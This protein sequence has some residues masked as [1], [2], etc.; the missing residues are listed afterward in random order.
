MEAE[1]N[2]TWKGFTRRDVAVQQFGCS[3][4]FKI[5]K[6]KRSSHLLPFF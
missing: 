6:R 5:L 4:I 2:N 3:L 1:R